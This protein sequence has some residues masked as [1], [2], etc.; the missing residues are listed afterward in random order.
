MESGEIR[1]QRSCTTL[2]AFT[3]FLS[4]LVIQESLLGIPGFRMIADTQ[5]SHIINEDLQ[6]D[7]PW[8]SVLLL[9]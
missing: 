7:R 4:L 8:V 2:P 6:E 1:E 9:V 5:L 3:G